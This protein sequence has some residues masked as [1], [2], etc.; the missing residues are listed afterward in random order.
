MIVAALRESDF[1]AV[2]SANSILI[3]MLETSVKE[4]LH[5]L[6]RVSFRTGNDVVSVPD[7]H[8]HRWNS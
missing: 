2:E 5:T 3:G 7:K 8:R 6:E 1:I 4:A